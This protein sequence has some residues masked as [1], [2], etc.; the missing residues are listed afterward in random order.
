MIEQSNAP[1][2][3]RSGNKGMMWSAQKFFKNE[4]LKLIVLGTL[5]LCP[6]RLMA[7]D[8]KPPTIAILIGNVEGAWA[9][10]F[11]KIA[12]LSF[13]F[14][15]RGIR[16]VVNYFASEKDLSEALRSPHV[17]GILWISHSVSTEGGIL[18]ANH[19]NVSEHTFRIISPSIRF[20]VLGSCCAEK[21]VAKHY[22]LLNREGVQLFYVVD[23]DRADG[24]ITPNGAIER[25]FENL[26]S[27]EMLLKALDLEF[28]TPQV[29]CTESVSPNSD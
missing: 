6:A 28:E 23:P 8:K 27:R 12:D 25:L 14:G 5:F 17:N 29:S 1:A 3:G 13:W 2:N 22:R 20:L 21:L 26:E 4:I 15:K 10:N 16:V 11:Y 19:K 7:V 18:D 9:S 24:T